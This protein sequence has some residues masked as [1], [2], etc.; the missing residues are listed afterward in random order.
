MCNILTKHS[1][2]DR[3]LIMITIMSDVKF[4]DLHGEEDN[5][6]HGLNLK[7]DV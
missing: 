6:G 2:N 4:D 1:V 3:L 5:E 7:L